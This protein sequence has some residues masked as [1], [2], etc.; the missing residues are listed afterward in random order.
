MIDE[1]RAD[2][3]LPKKFLW[4][5]ATFHP[6]KLPFDAEAAEKFLKGIQ[7]T[8]TKRLCQI[9]TT[10]KSKRTQYYPNYYIF[11]LSKGLGS[12]LSNS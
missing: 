7:S 6:I 8:K 3:D 9:V 4:K 11:R 12:T 5:S 1:F 2:V 10:E